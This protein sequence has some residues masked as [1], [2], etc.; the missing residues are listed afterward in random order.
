MVD[1]ADEFQKDPQLSLIGATIKSL[2]EEGV[3]FPSSGSKVFI[4]VLALSLVLR[5]DTDIW[6]Y[7]EIFCLICK[8]ELKNTGLTTA[9]R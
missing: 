6:I 8:L 1:W 3:T 9:V 7:S 4:Q 5:S 2:K